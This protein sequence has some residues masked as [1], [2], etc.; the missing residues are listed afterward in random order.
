MARST[1][2]IE[3][4]ILAAVDDAETDVETVDL[5][6]EAVRIPS[7]TGTDAESALQHWCARLL[8]EAD[9]NVD[10]WKL[11]LT[12]LTAAEGFPGLEAPRQE[13]YGVVGV[14]DGEGPPALVL[15]G[16]VDVVPTGI[17]PSGTATTPSPRG[18]PGPHCTAAGPAI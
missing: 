18:S 1:S 2:A 4:R 12:T 6:A 9:I 3:A 13:G 8:T 16:H 7:I 15:Q 5:L 10:V 11:D 14:A 17:G